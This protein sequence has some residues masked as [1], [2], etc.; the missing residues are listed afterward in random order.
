MFED[1]PDE[2][3]LPPSTDAAA[4][5]ADEQIGQVS[6]SSL[7]GLLWE[8]VR[9]LALRVDALDPPKNPKGDPAHG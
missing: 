6:I 4:E 8:G 7:V 9:Q 1:L 3:R 2:V 5:S